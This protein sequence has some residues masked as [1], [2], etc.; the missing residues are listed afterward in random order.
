MASDASW[1][2]EMPERYDAGLKAAVFEPCARM[3]AGRVADLAPAKVLEIAAGTGITTAE[4]VRLLP[5]AEVTATDLNPAMVQRGTR[6]VPGARWSVAAADAL[7]VPDAGTDALVCQFGVMFFPDRVAAFAEAART[8]RPGG[9]YL[10][11]VWDEV[12]TS[13]FAGAVHDSLVRML[14][15]DPP[16]FLARVPYG[17]HDIDAVRA[18]VAAGGLRTAAVDRVELSGVGT[19]RAAANGF[20]LGTPLRFDIAERADP[21]RTAAAVADDLAAR[22]G[23]GP[24]TGSLAA[25]VVTARAD[26]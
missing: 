20:C 16:P 24:I 21:V 4:L 22:L 17:C 11:T 2:D 3:L 10:F 5:G 26:G 15:D 9:S 25:F 8:L 7:G 18:E 1:I 6:A 23:E 19:A 14:P 13:T 12:H